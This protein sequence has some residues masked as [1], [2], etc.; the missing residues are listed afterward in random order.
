MIYWL[1]DRP[2][3]WSELVA[4]NYDQ[5][6]ERYEYLVKIQTEQAAE[7]KVGRDKVRSLVRPVQPTQTRAG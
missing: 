4:L 3:S 1:E 2:L 5:L 7:L 6:R